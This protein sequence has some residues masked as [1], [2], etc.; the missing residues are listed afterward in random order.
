MTHVTRIEKHKEGHRQPPF[1]S[2]K[3]PQTKIHLKADCQHLADNNMVDSTRDA[4]FAEVR[5]ATRGTGCFPI[6][7]LFPIDSLCIGQFTTMNLERE[8]GH[9]AP[10]IRRQVNRTLNV[11]IPGQTDED[12]NRVYIRLGDVLTHHDMSEGTRHIQNMICQKATRYTKNYP[13]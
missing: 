3:T 2:R 8:K 10:G 6:D 9:R 11:H 7:L 12:N 13:C 4:H 1:T 5:C